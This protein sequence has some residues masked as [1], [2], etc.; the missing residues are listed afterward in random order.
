MSSD[1][2]RLVIGA[3]NN[4]QPGSNAGH[5]RAFEWNGSSWVQIGSDIDGEAGFDQSGYSVSLSGNGSRV[6][7][8][9]GGNDDNGQSSGHVRVYET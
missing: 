4:D 3:I 5:V 1:G 2:T 9:A 6:A 7:I 8:G